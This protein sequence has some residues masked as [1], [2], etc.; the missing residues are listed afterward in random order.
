M[1][2]TRVSLTIAMILITFSCLA[3]EHPWEKY[4]FTPK[5]VTLSNGKYQELHDNDTLVEI[6]SAIF[7]R[8]NGKI[9]GIVKADT[10]INYEVLKPY[11]ISRWISPDPLSEEYFSWSPYNYCANNPM[12]YVDPDGREIRYTFENLESVLALVNMLL[13]A[14]DKYLQ[15]EFHF[16]FSKVEGENGAFSLNLAGSGDVS[17]LSIEGKKFYGYMKSM[18]T[19]K[20]VVLKQHIT[21][22]NENVWMVNPTSN[23]MDIA[24]YNS[25][26][27]KDSPTDPVTAFFHETYEQF[28]KTKD[29]YEAGEYEG[30]IHNTLFNSEGKWHSRAL[31]T[32]NK[33]GGYTRKVKYEYNRKGKKLPY[34][35][36]T[37]NDGRVYEQRVT[38]HMK[39]TLKG[40]LSVSTKRIK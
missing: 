34:S 30:F 38:F 26:D 35:V 24:D 39:G 8:K 2:K 15:D 3:Q 33:V 1:R 13:D 18:T 4:G 19:N 23:V 12:I 14:K 40:R 25:F 22:E 36:I 17:K 9:I 6:G 28:E 37:T 32:E 16:E 7:D 10:S 20:D 27:E 31:Q 29:G 11:V 5:I 21:T